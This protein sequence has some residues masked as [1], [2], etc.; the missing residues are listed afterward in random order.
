MITLDMTAAMAELNAML[1]RTANLKPVLH[2]I[3]ELEAN[4]VRARIQSTKIDPYDSE[5][6]PWAPFT[7][8]QR[9]LK[10]NVAQ[11]LL[12]DTGALLNSFVV[13]STI[14][15]V[16]IG[17]PVSYAEGLQFGD[18]RMPARE[19][20]GWNDSDFPIIEAL[21]IKYMELGI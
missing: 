7:A 16:T 5:W 3:G 17:T 12:W 18:A 10:G 13:E 6:A 11:G 14:A 15:S 2:A 19:F 4:K 1:A 21:V 9:A 8:I 20:M